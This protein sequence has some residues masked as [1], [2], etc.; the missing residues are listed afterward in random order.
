MTNGW[1][2]PWSKSEKSVASL[3][4]PRKTLGKTTVKINFT[5]QD[6]MQGDLNIGKY[7]VYI[8]YSFKVCFS[9]LL[10]IIVM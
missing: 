1:S 8:W 7:E 9:E 10:I 3:E 6:H 5:L 4:K 2:L